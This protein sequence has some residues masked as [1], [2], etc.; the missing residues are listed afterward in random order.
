MCCFSHFYIIVHQVESHLTVGMCTFVWS[1]LCPF[2]DAWCKGVYPEL[3]V[4]L[5]FRPFHMLQR[6]N[7]RNVRIHPQSE[8]QLHSYIIS[9]DWNASCLLTGSHTYFG[10]LLGQRS[11]HRCVDLNNV[12]SSVWVFN[13]LDLQ[14]LCFGAGNEEFTFPVEWAKC[15]GWGNAVSA[16]CLLAV[17]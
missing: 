13:L 9:Q 2:S 3:S 12:I 17:E 7:K 4:Q 15:G 11:Q 14:H 1:Y 6:E 10:Q 5:T 8:K 16:R